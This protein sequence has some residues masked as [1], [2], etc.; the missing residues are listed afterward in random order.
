MLKRLRSAP[1]LSAPLDY[2]WRPSLLSCCAKK[3]APT[4]RN[5]SH[6]KATDANTIK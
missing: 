6:N 3:R 4:Q 2:L 5:R 1:L